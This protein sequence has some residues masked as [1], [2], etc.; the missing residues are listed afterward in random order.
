MTSE[1]KYQYQGL[2]DKNGVHKLSDDWLELNFKSRFTDFYNHLLRMPVT[3]EYLDVPLGSRKSGNT[4]WPVTLKKG[5]SIYYRQID[6]DSSCLY[7]SIAM[8]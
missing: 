7:Y 1:S 2:D 4:D 5:P 3:G 8:L 6:G